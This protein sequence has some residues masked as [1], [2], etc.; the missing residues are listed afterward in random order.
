MRA[1]CCSYH[2]VPRMPT[3]LFLCIEQHHGGSVF[4]KIPPKRNYRIASSVELLTTAGV[5]GHVV[6]CIYVHVS[7]TPPRDLFCDPFVYRHTIEYQPIFLFPVL[8][9]C[10]Y[11]TC[12]RKYANAS[13]ML[14]ILSLASMQAGFN[15]PP[16]P[17]FIGTEFSAVRSCVKDEP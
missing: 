9:R 6:W 13:D 14:T 4:C 3:T 12:E 16:T 17:S 7:P 2:A 8:F 5:A 11:L 10:S 1:F 15:A